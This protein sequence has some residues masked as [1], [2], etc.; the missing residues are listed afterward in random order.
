MLY[1]IYIQ[2]NNLKMHENHSAA[3]FK[4]TKFLK[5]LISNQYMSAICPLNNNNQKS[6]D[7]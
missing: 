2:N 6:F 7:T 3:K 4:Y 5:T 1:Y